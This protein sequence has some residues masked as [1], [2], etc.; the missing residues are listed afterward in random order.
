MRPRLSVE[1]VG[2]DDG[3]IAPDT[4]TSRVP[5]ACPPSRIPTTR[6][7]TAVSDISFT[8]R[9]FIPTPFEAAYRQDTDQATGNEGIVDRGHSSCKIYCGGIDRCDEISFFYWAWLLF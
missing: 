5:P 9:N 4:I 8:V 3:G 6:A 7:T 1:K 2:M